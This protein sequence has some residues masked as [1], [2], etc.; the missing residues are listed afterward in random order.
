[1]AIKLQLSSSEI[2]NKQFNIENFGYEAIEVDKFLDSVIRDYLLIETN[3]LIEKK[4]LDKIQ[5]EN[6]ELKKR[7][8]SLEIE[9]ASLK[10]KLKFYEENPNASVENIDLIKRIS[11]LEKYLFKHGVNPNTIK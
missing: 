11:T 6:A 8:S 7:V 2:L 10:K 5:E 9:N 4:M 3:Y 1:M